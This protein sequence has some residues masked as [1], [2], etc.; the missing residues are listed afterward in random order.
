[1]KFALLAAS[2]LAL[3]V[4]AFAQDTTTTPPAE[5][6]TMQT[7][8]STMAQDPAMQTTPA[9]PAAA[10]TDPSTA[11]ATAPA[12]DPAMATTGTMTEGGYAPSTPPMSGTPQPGAQVVFK[13]SVP[14]AQAFPPPPPKD[15]YPVCRGSVQ[16]GC[17]NPGGV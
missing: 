5:P 16:D 14:V 2:A 15:E 7:Q 17:R 12:T 3:S 10:P 9:D 13:P 1:M 4:P 8:D 11:R 6:D